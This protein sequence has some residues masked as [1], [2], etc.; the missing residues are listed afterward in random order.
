M[1]IFL[2]GTVSFS[3]KVLE[4]LLYINAEIVGVATKFKSDFNADHIDL[5]PLCIENNIAVKYIKDINAPHV[6]KWIDSLQPDVIF[7]CGWS[8]LIKRKLLE[9][10]KLGVV[11][12]HP[13]ELPENRGRHPIIWSIALGL[14]TGA[15]TFFFMEEGADSGDILSQK[16][17][18][19]LYEDDAAS[20]YLKMEKS[21][22]EQIEEI[23]PSLQKGNNKRSRQ[24]H[25]RGNI[26]RKR[27]IKD[28]EIDFRMSSF[29]LY[30]LVRALAK[31]YVGAHLYYKEKEIKIWKVKEEIFSAK[32]IEPGK[33]LASE[34]KEILVK[35]YDGAVRILSHGFT[36][37]PQKGEYL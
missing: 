37:I 6:T 23:I 4:K 1:K 21:A 22:L 9:L 15:A 17:F 29:A 5:T 3:K 25:S 8:S 26:W 13:T 14:E 32:N 24:D 7:C 27:G 12:F 20:V 19:I 31:P 33:V 30:N 10:P 35:T 28:G 36:E 16:T 34:G 18:P 2:I 11:G